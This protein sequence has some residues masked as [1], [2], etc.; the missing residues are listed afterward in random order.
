MASA[1]ELVILPECLG[2]LGVEIGGKVVDVD[3]LGRFLARLHP[4]QRKVDRPVRDLAKELD[5]REVSE[6]VSANLL[7]GN[8]GQTIIAC[9]QKVGCFH[10]SVFFHV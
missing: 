9:E 1:V 8:D 3:A 5:G 10:I 7:N 6:E 2:A 4:D